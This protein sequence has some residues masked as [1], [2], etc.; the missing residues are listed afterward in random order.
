MR[1]LIALSL[2]SATLMSAT[3][4]G[5]AIADVPSAPVRGEQRVV[6]ACERDAATRRGFAREHGAQPVFVTAEQVMA[7]SRRGETWATPRCMAP[8]EHARLVRLL[9]ARP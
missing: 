6:M 7:A 3:W 2:A 4:A 5:A 9:K 8:R 1:T